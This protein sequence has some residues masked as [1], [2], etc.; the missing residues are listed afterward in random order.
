MTRIKLLLLLCIFVQLKLSA[1]VKIGD[2][3]NTIS[4]AS[5]VEMETTNKGFVPPRVVLTSLTSSSPLP[6]TLLTGTVVFNTAAGV[7]SGIGLYYWNGSAWVAVGGSSSSAWSILGNTGTN[8]GINFLGTTDNISVRFRTNG[9][10][11]M[12]IDSNGR[13]GIGT[14]NPLNALSVIATN[15]LYL[16]GVQATSTITSDSVLTI[17]A[18]VVK[19][20]P[21]SSFSGGGGTSWLLTGN[22][23]TNSATNFVGTLDD[24]ALVF[25]TN[26]ITAGF[27]G[28]T[29][30]G[31]G[32]TSLGRSASAGDQN[33]TAIGTGA[34]ASANQSTALGFSASATSQNAVAAGANAAAGQTAAIA[35]GFNSVA[36]AQQ[37]IA[38][39]NAAVASNSLNNIAIGTSAAASVQNGV[40]IG[41]NAKAISSTTAMAIGNG[42]I[43][44]G[45][46]STAIGDGASASQQ[47]SLAFGVSAAASGT[48]AI[49]MGNS[50][51]ASANNSTAFGVGAQAT[52]TGGNA[53]GNVSL[54]SGVN[55]TVVG[56]S[57]T[58]SGDN[59]IVVGDKSTA[60]GSNTIVLG[61]GSSVTAGT[62]STIVIGDGLT[63]V[64]QS[65]I[66]VLGNSAKTVAISTVTPNPNAR[67]D[68]NGTFKF[69]ANGTV[70]SAVINSA[71]ATATTQASTIA[72]NTMGTATVAVSNAV[73]NAPVIVSPR[74]FPANPFVIAYARVTSTGTVTIGIYNTS[75]ATI[76][77]G[78]TFQ[79]DVV[80]VNP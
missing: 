2:N 69:G 3:P 50:S 48:G 44:S 70:M 39:G 30:D 41:P 29:N 52:T 40:A 63:N 35:L 33:A 80:V 7:G 36:S 53:F 58:G 14:R 77:A 62:T 75:G 37:S 15:P 43:A 54:A 27:I 4:S 51:V 59:S 78:T 1:Q 23:G 47:A 12:V 79:V 16:S 67:L 71:G 46:S 61:A 6:A 73:Q 28:S 74:T 42:A 22:S 68:V 34:N 56:N 13:V 25:R 60:A 66:L 45:Q 55:S 31:I 10:E 9:T 76:N 57:S 21:V 32:R 72:I 17:N 18:G 64:S 38:I 65:N 11:R 20:T 24:H 5:L 8:S 19:K 49:A 26:N